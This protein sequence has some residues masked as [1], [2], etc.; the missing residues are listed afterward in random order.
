M[1]DHSVESLSLRKTTEDPKGSQAGGIWTL[2]GLLSSRA[3]SLCYWQV[4]ASLALP[5]LWKFLDP[6]AALPKPVRIL[7]WTRWRA[8]NSQV[9]VWEVCSLMPLDLWLETEILLDLLAE[10][11][12]VSEQLV[13]VLVVVI[14]LVSTLP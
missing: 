8:R 13:S 9:L 2:P 6:L 4:V 1:L 14:Q 5:A 11:Q 12:V 7:S 3:H 10:E